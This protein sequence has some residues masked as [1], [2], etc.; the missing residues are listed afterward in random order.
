MLKIIIEKMNSSL[1]YEC[2]GIIIQLMIGFPSETIEA[3]DIKMTYSVVLKITIF[4]QLK[5]I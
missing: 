5:F 1:C 2:P 3:E 4:C